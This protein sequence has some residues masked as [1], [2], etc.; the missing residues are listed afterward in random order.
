MVNNNVMTA[1]RLAD[2]LR[3]DGHKAEIKTF[4][5][6]GQTVVGT[7]LRDN[8]RFVLE[9]EFN[10]KGNNMNVICP[11]GNPTARFSADQLLA[12]MKK[13][14]ELPTPVHFAYRAG[15]QR[16]CLE[17]PNYATFNMTAAG[18]RSILDR[19][20]KT[21]HDTYPLWDTNRWPV[22][23]PAPAAQAPVAAPA[24][25]PG[26]VNTTWVGSENLGGYG[27]LE[28]RFQANGQVTMIDSDGTQQGTCTVAGNTVTL[29][30]YQGTVVYTGTLTGQGLAGTATN[31]KSTWKFAVSR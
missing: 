10:S 17:D 20:M 18:L 25:N 12:L 5:N 31:G 11:L 8:W 16:L 3:L 23:G 6:G 30:F 24:V 27:R 15:D 9:F 2:L 26:L 21:A 13:S 28:F 22:N 29:R 1:N 4:K 14:Y 7:I 19:V